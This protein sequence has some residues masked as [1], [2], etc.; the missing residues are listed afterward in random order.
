MN[1]LVRVYRNVNI[2]I[3]KEFRTLVEARRFAKQYKRYAI[4][5]LVERVEKE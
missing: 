4:F 1:Y 3:C 5:K 2:D